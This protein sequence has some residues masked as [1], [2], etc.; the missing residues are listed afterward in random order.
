M[1]LEFSD[2]GLTPEEKVASRKQAL[3]AY[4]NVAQPMEKERQGMERGKLASDV[5]SA[6]A[7]AAK[8]GDNAGISDIMAKAQQQASELIP[9]QQQK[10]QDLAYQGAQYKEDILGSKQ[11]AAV[12]NYERNTV[13]YKDKM[14]DQLAKQAFEMGYQAK[15]LALSQNGA[16]A[17]RGLQ[18]L[19]KDLQAGRVNKEEISGLQYQLAT[20][21]QQ[22]K[23]DLDKELA[24]QKGQLELELKS[25]NLTAA[26]ARMQKIIDKQKEIA[27]DAA[28]AGALGGILSGIVAIGGGVAATAITGNPFMF[29]P[30]YRAT[31]DLT[32]GISK[33]AGG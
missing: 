22:M 8:E 5:Y 9:Q 25:K 13:E 18:Q 10:Q 21:A 26:K 11:E 20:R 31:E 14:S 29:Y 1:A 2:W 7:K 19:Y 32:S 23:A 17:D 6:S 15:E 16:L 30:G 33:V 4:F 27:K 28:K 12:G 3:D 24:T